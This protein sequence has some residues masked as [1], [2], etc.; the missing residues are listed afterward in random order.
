VETV[1][2]QYYKGHAVNIPSAEQAFQACSKLSSFFA[3]AVVSELTPDRLDAFVAWMREAGSSDGY[4]A[5]TLSTL[6]AALNRAWKRQEIIRVPFIPLPQNGPPRERRLSIEESAALLN[7]CEAEHLYVFVVLAFATLA[8]PGAL[9]ELRREQ[10]DLRDG[11]IHLNPP[12]RRQTKKYRPA[13][14]L[15]PILRPWVEALPNGPLISY[16][17]EQVKSIK[18]AF[19]AT[20]L[21]AGLDES[22]T[23]YTIRHTMATELRKRAVPSWEVSGMLGHQ[24]A[25][26]RTTEIYAKYDP[27]YLGQAVRAIEAWFIEL[28]C[29]LRR[30]VLTPFSRD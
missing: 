30:D 5:R 12:G 1:L 13:L 21:K 3:G 15:A 7:A 14:P 2:V 17:G 8:R 19:R 26:F 6:K 18:T 4:I 28:N 10:I 25:G 20:R 23:P 27:S 29:L 24:S 16:Y 11:L 9:L 22:V